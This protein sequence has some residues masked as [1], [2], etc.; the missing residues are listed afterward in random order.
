[1][2]EGKAPGGLIALAVFNFIFAANNALSTVGNFGIGA[3]V[4]SDA[5]VPE[6][7]GEQFRDM[8]TM[9]REQDL[10][11]TILALATGAGAL[12]VLQVVSGIGYLKLKRGLGWKCGNIYAIASIALTVIPTF[13]MNLPDADELGGGFQLLTLLFVIYPLL[14]L[15]LLNTTFKHDFV[16]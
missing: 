5:E 16:R 11:M 8:I 13:L 2:S 12:T 1:M 6:A 10:G 15:I 14:T 9:M 4:I 7:M 3:L